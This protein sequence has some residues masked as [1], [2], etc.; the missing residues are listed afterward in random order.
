MK[1]GKF[2]SIF[3][4]ALAFML[5]GASPASAATQTDLEFGLNSPSGNYLVGVF[6]SKLR[7]TDIAAKYLGRA[8]SDDPDNRNLVE[9]A[10]ILSLS[11]GY[12]D[13]AEAL[14]ERVVRYNKRH[15]M[16]HIVLGLRE[17]RKKRF[18][19]A[20]EHFKQAGYTP[21]GELTSALLAAWSFAA[22]GKVTETFK[23]LDTLDK[24]DAF[25]NFKLFHG[26]LIA[27]F[28]GQ[29]SRADQTYKQAYEQ[30]GTTL[31]V[32]QSYGNYLHRAGRNDEASEVF[33]KY[34]NSS[35]RS[36][37]VQVALDKLNN[38]QTPGKF[39]SSAAEGM[40]ES[41]FSIA[42]ALSDEQNIDVSLIYVQLALS[43]RSDFDVARVLLGE[44]YEDTKRHGK[45]VETF[46]SVPASSPLK[47]NAEIQAAVNLDH[48][49]R[50]DEAINALNAFVARNPKHFD[51]NVTLG[52]IQRSHEKWE[53]AIV[54]Y[55]RAID[56]VPEI[57]ENHWILM[58]F[59]GIAHERAKKWEL[60]EPDFL[61]ALELKPEQPAVLNYL[62][63]SWIEKGLNLKKAIGMVAKAVELRP[64]DGYIVDSLGWAHYQLGEFE[65]AVKHLE[66]AVE[67]RP[68]DPVINDHLGDAYWRVGRKLEAKFQWRHAKDNK[69]IEKD[70]K[71]IEEKL[72]KG[73]PDLEEPAPSANGSQPPS[74][75]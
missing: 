46:Q 1:Q 68:E 41:M 5:T 35:R 61:K 36:P 75:S 16:S 45:A 70:L 17:A 11:S 64:N 20:R 12:I 67:L 55:S 15:R 50:T 60:A 7:D 66:R 48:L 43:M 31:R 27:D 9:R 59:R 18:E 4:A 73:M 30:A 62:G 13:R 2:G 51:A 3:A 42:S 49:E 44:I 33:K 71:I 10:F 14:A 57:K 21:V 38:K 39:I 56:V 6:A 8:L 47:D 72:L 25:G 63:Y 52:N 29:P 34:L 58:Y 32:V 22:Q 40:A 65:D 28:L 69:P 54:S 37:L 24:N 26:A 19:T 74:K 23:A 53:D